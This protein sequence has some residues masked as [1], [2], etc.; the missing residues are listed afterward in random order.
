MF[1]LDIYIVADESGT[2]YAMK[3]HRYSNLKQ[4]VYQLCLADWT[5][6]QY[7]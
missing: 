7:L 5:G 4:L 3:I 6:N 1:T 2:Q